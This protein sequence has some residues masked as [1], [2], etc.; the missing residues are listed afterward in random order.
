MK[1]TTLLTYALPALPLAALTLPLYIIVPTFYSETLGLPL[2]AVGSA[3]LLVR[4]LDAVSDPLIGWAADRWRPGIGRR[5]AVFVLSL[6]LTSLACVMVFWP[7]AGAGTSY[8]AFWGTALS[9]GYTATLLP[10]TAWGAELAG[11]YAER[12]RIAAFREGMTLVGTLV[13]I[14]VPFA[15]GVETADGVHG[16][17]ALGLLTAALL[18]MLGGLTAVAVPEPVEYSMSRVSLVAGLGHMV[19]N[20]PFL[21]LIA[22][23]FV[24]G[25]ANGIPATLFLYF[26]SERLGAAEMRG[27][28]LFVYFLSGIAGVPLAVRLAARVGKHRAWCLAMLVNCALFSLVPLL[29]EGDVLAFGAICVAT[30]FCLGFDLSLPAS[31][32]ADVIDVDTAASGEQRSGLY[33]A[34]WSLSTKLSLAAGVGI[35]FPLLALFG[36]VPDGPNDAGAVTALVSIYVWLPLALKVGA[37]MLMWSFPLGEAEQRV[38][39]SSIEARRG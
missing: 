22:A 21:R 28:L 36:F 17:A 9:L 3:L 38:L 18:L 20:R 34:A 25:L 27:P 1:P 19:R 32:Q 13:A 24:N 16:L 39:R 2:A 5:R 37:I 23:Y 4:I 6:P 29:G 35:V 11:G 12:S 30:G 14:A 8:L 15:V 7:P 31:I 10:Y 26:V 33:F